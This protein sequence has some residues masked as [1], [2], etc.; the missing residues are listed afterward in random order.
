MQV[1]SATAFAE[2]DDGVPAESV[3]A[4]YPTL[5]AAN[6]RSV[7]AY[8]SQASFLDIGT[9]RDCLDTSLAL[10]HEEGA[11]FTGADSRVAISAV[12]VRTHAVG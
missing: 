12:L 11:R 2:L 9:P 1:A 5:I 7:A 6:P 10:A 8:V 4:L 3:N